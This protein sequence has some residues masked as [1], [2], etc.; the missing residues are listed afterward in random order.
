MA[1]AGPGDDLDEVRIWRARGVVR[2]VAA[3]LIVLPDDENPQASSPMR[4]CNCR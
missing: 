1:E 3:G 2:A 4:E